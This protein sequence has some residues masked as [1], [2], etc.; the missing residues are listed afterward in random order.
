MLKYYLY[1]IAQTIASAL[2]ISVAYCIAVFLSDI[3]YFVSPRDRK[4]VHDNLFVILNDHEKA[5][6]IA[7]EVF[8]NFGKYLTEFFRMEKFT[9]AFVKQNVV[10]ENRELLEEGLKKGR[11][12]IIMTAH[13][14]NWELGG[15]ALSRFGFPLT[16]IALPHRERSVN[17]LFNH[18]RE[19]AGVTVVPVHSAIRRC[20]RTL[21]QNGIIALLADRDFSATGIP[22]DFFNRRTMIPRGPAMF[23]YRTGATVLPMFLTRNPDGTFRISISEPLDLPDD[24]QKMDEREFNHHF[25]KQ[26]VTALEKAIKR[27]PSQWLVFRKFWIDEECGPERITST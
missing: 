9:E 12:V 19:S 1:K 21:K 2:P 4:A 7:R 3:K 25:A 24:P 15:L 13:I 14:G 27:N 22:M 5:H 20:I 10:L 8:Q 16:A 17:E 6:Q 23:A 26:Q 18:Q 11:G